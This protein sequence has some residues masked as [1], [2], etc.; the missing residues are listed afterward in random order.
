M[1]HVTE[2]VIFFFLYLVFIGLTEIV[3]CGYHSGW[4]ALD[5]LGPDFLQD[6]GKGPGRGKVRAGTGPR[7]AQTQAECT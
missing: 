3:P 5:T 4:S 2:T 6:A 7:V 1:A